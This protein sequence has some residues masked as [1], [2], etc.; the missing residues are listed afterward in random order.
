MRQTP[1]NTMAS[2]LQA[3]SKL[4]LGRP[5]AEPWCS[6]SG[7]LHNQKWSAGEAA[8]DGHKPNVLGALASPRCSQVQVHSQAACVRIRATFQ[9][10]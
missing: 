10:P 1:R 6:S 9:L 7:I 3:V 5:V 2:T 4:R 8:L